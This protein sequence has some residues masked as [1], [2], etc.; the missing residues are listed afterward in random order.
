[1]KKELLTVPISFRLSAKEYKPYGDIIKKNGLKKSKFIRDV[2]LNASI[3]ED[4]KIVVKKTKVEDYKRVVFVA[5]KSSN[6]I[7]QIAKKLNL[8][9]KNGTVNESLYVEMLNRL[10][11]VEKLFKSAIKN[12]S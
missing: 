2:F 9:Y 5:N 3:D 7:N 10:I 1:M 4:G 8:A 12:V 6:N 11:G